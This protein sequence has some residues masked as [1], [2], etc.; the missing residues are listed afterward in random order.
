MLV[1]L[2]VG[3]HGRRGY[4]VAAVG[5]TAPGVSVPLPDA[6]S[7]GVA[8]AEGESV[9]E[10]VTVGDAEDVGDADVDGDEDVVADV[11]GD[12]PLVDGVG[13]ATGEPLDADGLG[14][15]EEVDAVQVGVGE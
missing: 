2:A 4:D 1:R 5:V 8:V 14:V 10:P 15:S 13:D 12:A 6:E 7:V 9:G 3:P 11:V